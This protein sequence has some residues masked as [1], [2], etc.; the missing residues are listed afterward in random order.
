M[1]AAHHD[2][3]TQYALYSISYQQFPKSIFGHI[4]SHVTLTFDLLTSTSNQFIFVPNR[5][6]I[7]NLVKF[8][9]GGCKI[10]Y[11]QIFQYMILHTPVQPENR[12]PLAANHWQR[13][14]SS[15]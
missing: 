4:W 3:L 6:N 13:D 1:V 7:V 10:S 11:L 9:K 5:T 8:P 2:N 12:V 14:K 15:S